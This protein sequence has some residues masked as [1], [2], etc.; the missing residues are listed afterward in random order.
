MRSIQ[1]ELW[2]ESDVS[3]PPQV[4][5]QQVITDEVHGHITNEELEVNEDPNERRPASLRFIH[6]TDIHVGITG[7]NWLYPNIEEKFFEDLRSQHRR[8]GPYDLLIF[9]GDLTQKGSKEEFD[10][11]QQRLDRIFDV[12]RKE[13]STP[14][15]LAVPGNHDLERP[16]D[17][18][19]VKTSRTWG[20]KDSKEIGDEFYERSGYFH[21]QIVKA[22]SNYHSWWAPYAKELPSVQEGLLPGEYATS[23]QIQGRRVGVVAL[24]TAFLHL[25]AGEKKGTLSL[26]P[27]Q[28]SH[29]FPEGAGQWAKEHDLCLLLSHHPPDWLDKDARAAL[30]A[31]INPT[32]PHARFAIHLYGHDHEGDVEQHASGGAGLR[33]ALLGRSLFGLEFYE[34][35]ELRSHGYSIGAVDLPVGKERSLKLWPRKGKKTKN[36]WQLVADDNFALTEECTKPLL[37]GPSPRIES[38]LA[39]VHVGSEEVD[40]NDSGEPIPVHQPPSSP[41]VPTPQSKWHARF[42]A[43]LPIQNEAVRL[44]FVRDMLKENFG[45]NY[46][47]VLAAVREIDDDVEGHIQDPKL[48]AEDWRFQLVDQLRMRGVLYERP[49][50]EALIKVAPALKKAEIARLRDAFCPA[51]IAPRR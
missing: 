24:N 40:A 5:P 47:T 46:S 38:G 32:I 49:F 44:G 12:L 9:T 22:F 30:K 15:L 25:E 29:L 6:L 50:W 21:D 27:R 45:S 48:S 23:L 34:E 8:S 1:T 41:P 13:G 35:G 11:F 3:D 19:V 28:L 37:L 16:K 43:A 20:D 4:E 26:D 17:K 10:R 39:Q 51:P 7:E 42:V 36:G 31:E 2:W 14:L 33:T 18:L